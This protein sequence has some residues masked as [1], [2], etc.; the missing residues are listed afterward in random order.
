VGLADRPAWLD[1]ASTLSRFGATRAAQ[2]RWYREFVGSGAPEDPMR[3]AAH[4]AVLGTPGFVERVRQALGERAADTEVSR[5][6]AA[7]ARPTLETLFRT[8]ARGYSVDARSLCRK[9]KRRNEARD[10]AVYLARRHWGIPLREIGEFVGDLGSA[11]VSL[12]HR[13]I[14]ERLPCDPALRR[15]VAAL[16]REVAAA[17]SGGGED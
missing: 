5:L 16:E 14:A 17:R 6:Q 7:R 11:A 10:V 2:T 1:I 4:G 9:G 3:R 15:R 13:R 8:V 12:A